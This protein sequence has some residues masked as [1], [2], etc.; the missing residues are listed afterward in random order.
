MHSYLKIFWL[1]AVDNLETDRN[2]DDDN[3][4]YDDDDCD[5]DDDVMMM[6]MGREGSL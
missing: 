3:D 4:E 5:D 1:S 2:D 6:M